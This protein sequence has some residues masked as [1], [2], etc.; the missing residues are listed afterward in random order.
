MKNIGIS[1][2]FDKLTQT[3]VLDDSATSVESPSKSK[4]A[5]NKMNSNNKK[6]TISKST[7]TSYSG[8]TG[9]ADRRGTES[10]MSTSEIANHTLENR[11][12]TGRF[13]VVTCKIDDFDNPGNETL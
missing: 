4:E 6:D 10:G 12:R 2:R 8:N 3:W 1:Y 5:D 11:A 7:T 13:G 9:V